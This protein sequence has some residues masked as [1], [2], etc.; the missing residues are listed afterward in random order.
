M[1]KLVNTVKG[2]KAFDFKSNQV[3][4]KLAFKMIKDVEPRIVGEDNYAEAM[5]DRLPS[6]CAEIA[7]ALSAGI[8]EA[9][10]AGIAE[11]LS[12]KTTAS[13]T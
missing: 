13:G 11:A 5:F 10:S 6:V 7:E 9:L 2:C 8:A 12:S 4:C 3:Q 1:L